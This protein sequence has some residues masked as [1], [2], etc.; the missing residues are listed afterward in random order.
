MAESH[1]TAELHSTK[2]NSNK[3]TQIFP[4]NRKLKVRSSYYYEPYHAAWHRERRVP[5]SV[6]WI[7]IKG[8]W[9]KEAGFVIDTKLNVEISEG[10]IVL[11]FDPV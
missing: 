4:Y 8:Y 9:L 3:P 7:N 5:E 6:P 10:R 2:E 11:T 1:S